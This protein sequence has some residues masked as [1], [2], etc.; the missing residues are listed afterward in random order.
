MGA[1]VTKE[2]FSA[3]PEQQESLHGLAHAALAGR[4]TVCMCEPFLR[5]ANRLHGPLLAGALHSAA[6]VTRS[7]NMPGRAQVPS[8]LAV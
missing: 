3:V 7:H 1:H 2:G 8:S 6:R 5:V 4:H